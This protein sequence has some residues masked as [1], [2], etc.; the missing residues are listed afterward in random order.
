MFL[1]KVGSRWFNGTAI[2]QVGVNDN[3]QYTL[4][5]NLHSKMN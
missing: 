1:T 3:N 4:R 5:G 2:F